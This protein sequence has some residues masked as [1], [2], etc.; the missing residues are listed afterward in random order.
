M[1]RG[2]T[3]VD[4][5]SLYLYDLQIDSLNLDN[6][7]RAIEGENVSHSKCSHCVGWQPNEN[8]FKQ[9]KKLKGN[10]NS[11]HLSI[12]LTPKISLTNTTIKIQIRV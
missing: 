10:K 2:E 12:Y 3:F 7:L 4:Q 5:K 8:C 6:V 11:G 9:Q 1:R